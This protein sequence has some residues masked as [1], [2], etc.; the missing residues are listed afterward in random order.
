ME[1]NVPVLNNL[2]NLGSRK[3]NIIMSRIRMKSSILNGHLFQLKLVNDSRCKCGYMFE[4]T[5]HYF[6]VCP[7]YT[8]A[9][10]TLFNI[11]SPICSPTVHVLL[12]GCPELDFDLNKRLYLQTIRY[13]Q[14]TKRFD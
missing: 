6:L 8:D 3:Y 4:D 9:R 5:V 11:V 1:K 2:F 14:A 13:I 10:T 7:L 12:N